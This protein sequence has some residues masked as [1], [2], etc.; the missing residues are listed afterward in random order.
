MGNK[1]KACKLVKLMHEKRI[2]SCL[3]NFTFVGFNLVLF[4]NR[5]IFGTL[6]VKNFKT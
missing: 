4:L 6:G 1:K 5:D 3:T 2:Q